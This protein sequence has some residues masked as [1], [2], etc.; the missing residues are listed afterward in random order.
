MPTRRKTARVLPP[1]M[2]E[3]VERGV[4]ACTREIFDIAWN[5]TDAQYL[6]F[7]FNVMD[8]SAAPGVTA[9]EPGGLESRE[10]MRIAS[11]IGARGSVGV[12]DVSELCPI[13]DVSGTTSR[14]AVCVVLR[15]LAAMA[16]SRGELV[17][18]GIK[19]PVQ[20]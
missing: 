10:M 9:S 14:L 5:G 8:A 12:I 4:D 6:S 15:I 13:F 17:D 11:A 18:Q 2:T 7:N 3:V 19:R 1:T 20:D 16:R